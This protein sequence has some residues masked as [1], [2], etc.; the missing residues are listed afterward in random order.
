MDGIMQGRMDGGQDV[1]CFSNTCCRKGV[2]MCIKKTVGMW[3]LVCSKR[4]ESCLCRLLVVVVVK[5][6]S[7]MEIEI[8]GSEAV[9]RAR[10]GR[11]WQVVEWANPG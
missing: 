11:L 10:N 3:E 1:E 6:H 2:G 9:R 5:R 7:A 8:G 4:K